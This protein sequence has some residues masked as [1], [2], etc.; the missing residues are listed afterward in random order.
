MN[1]GARLLKPTGPVALAP[2]VAFSQRNNDREQRSMSFLIPA[3]DIYHNRFSVE[4]R[5][6]YFSRKRLVRKLSFSAE[7][8]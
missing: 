4:L 5:I 8:A 7:N 6:R 1:G 2:P 3:A